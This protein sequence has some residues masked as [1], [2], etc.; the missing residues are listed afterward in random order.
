[1]SL[2]FFLEILREIQ[3]QNGIE[4]LNKTIQEKNKMD[5]EIAQV[6]FFNLI[7]FFYSLYH[8]Y[9]LLKKV[10][11][12]N[13]KFSKLLFSYSILNLLAMILFF[14]IVHVFGNNGDWS[15]FFYFGVI[16]L[17]FILNAVV[18]LVTLV[19]SNQF[20]E[21]IKYFFILLSEDLVFVIVQCITISLA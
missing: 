1:M 2:F 20:A 19:V 5:R 7:W 10:K 15:I 11:L 3:K 18:F 21:F 13:L 6:T 17:F 12:I 9:F 8:N 14:L 16:C 4:N